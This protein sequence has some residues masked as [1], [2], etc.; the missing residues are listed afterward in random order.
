ML[1]E[2]A[3]EPLARF[4]HASNEPHVLHRNA[5]PAPYQ[6][7]VID[8][9]KGNRHRCL[10]KQLE[11]AATPVTPRPLRQGGSNVQ[12]CA[13]DR[14]HHRPPAFSRSTKVCLTPTS[15]PKLHYAPRMRA[16]PLHKDDL[17]DDLPPLDG[18]DEND[19]PPS[20]TFDEDQLSSFEAITGDE[21]DGQAE[22]ALP[23]GE[24]VDLP[25]DP[26]GASDEADAAPSEVDTGQDDIFLIDASETRADDDQDGVD[27]DDASLGVDALG[28]L[29]ADDGTEGTQDPLDSEVDESAFPELDSDEEADLPGGVDVGELDLPEEAPMPSWSEALWHRA[30]T[31]LVADPMRAVVCTA[32]L[33][34]AAG[35]GACVLALDRESVGTCHNVPLD[36]SETVEFISVGLCLPDA[37]LLLASRQRIL[38]TTQAGDPRRWFDGDLRAEDGFQR[39]EFGGTEEAFAYAMT[40]HGDLRVSADH[41]RTWRTMDGVGKVLALTVDEAGSAH[42]LAVSEGSCRWLRTDKHGQWESVPLHTPEDLV[43]GEVAAIAV[44]AGTWAIALER[45]ELLAS[46]DDGET[47]AVAKVPPGV[48]GLTV[49]PSNGSNTVVGT[50]YLESQDRSYLFAWT[51]GE[52]PVLVADLSPDVT[53]GTP[54]LDPSEGLGRAHHVVWDP[55]RGCVWVAGAFGLCAWSPTLPA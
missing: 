53:I 13:S 21:L 7:I 48:R 32:S 3:R 31:P 17:L 20:D 1:C 25:Y 2:H 26:S 52:E 28:D 27:G 36:E 15:P 46:S 22:H 37:R 33:V 10:D 38:E 11:R 19:T 45:G 24:L 54:D 35:E 34:V 9:G 14:F 6:R 41:G 42:V 47:W 43:R 12:S 50:L 39:V 18:D 51:P 8:R 29:E 30:S 44:G 4:E 40:T 5:N 55:F 16:T 49:A 23:V